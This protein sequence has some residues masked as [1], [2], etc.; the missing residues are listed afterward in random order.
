MYGFTTKIK[1]LVLA[2]PLPTVFLKESGF[3][4]FDILCSPANKI[5]QLRVKCEL[6]IEG[7]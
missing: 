6:E 7:V 4:T 5:V 2:K 1:M 3:T